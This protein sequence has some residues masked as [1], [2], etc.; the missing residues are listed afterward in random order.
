MNIRDYLN[1]KVVPAYVGLIIC[2]VLFG[3]SGFVAAELRLFF[4]PLIPF[5][6]FGAILTYLYFGVRCPNCRNSISYLSYLPKGGAFRLSKNLRFCPFC[7]VSLDTEV[8]AAGQLTA[9]T[10]ARARR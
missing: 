8:D 9:P 5:A 10:D 1:R 2:F 6:G 4:L 3:A 7:G